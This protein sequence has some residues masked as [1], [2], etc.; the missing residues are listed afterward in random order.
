MEPLK[1]AVQNWCKVDEIESGNEPGQGTTFIIH[2]PRYLGEAGQTPAESASVQIPTG[3]ET[4]L[5]VQNEPALLEM[6]SVILAKAGLTAIAGRPGDVPS[7]QTKSDPDPE[8][9][10]ILGTSPVSPS[11]KAPLSIVF[12]A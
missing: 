8:S 11:D 1:D 3:N 4:I 5:P 6:T 10:T 7:M 9:V 12:F 2:L